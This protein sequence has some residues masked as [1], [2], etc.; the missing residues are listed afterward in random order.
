MENTELNKLLQQ[1]QDEIK[2][3]QAV[4][5]KGSELLRG[6]DDEIHTLLEKSDANPEL[7]EQTDV[8]RL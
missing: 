6:L 3:T 7:L 4:D 8:Q 1:L 2:N 5:E